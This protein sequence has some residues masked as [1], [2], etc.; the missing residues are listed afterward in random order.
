MGFGSVRAVAT[1]GAFGSVLTFAASALGSPDLILDGQTL[2]TQGKLRHH[3][4]LLKNNS[5]LVVTPYDGQSG[6][7]RLEIVAHRIV[8]EAGS[9]IDASGAGYPGVHNADGSGPGGG[10]GATAT[11]HATGGGGYYGTGGPGVANDCTAYSG[12]LGGA[13]YDTGESDVSIGSAGSAAGVLDADDGG[14]G[15]NGA[16]AILLR[17]GY[18]EIDGKV[19]ADG[20]PG[21]PYDHSDCAGGG[22]GGGILISAWKLAAFQGSISAAG[23]VG[24][25]SVVNEGGGGGGGRILLFVDAQPP[26]LTVSVAGGHGTCA[27]AFGADGSLALKP[28]PGCVDIDQ[29]GVKSNECETANGDCDDSDP[30]IH[31]GAIEICNGVDDDCSGVADDNGA[32]ASCPSGVCTNGSC[33]EVDAGADGSLPLPDAGVDGA[34]D[35]DATP[36]ADS[37][38]SADSADASPPGE[39][40][41]TMDLV[42]RGGCTEATGEA[43]SASGVALFVVALLMRVRRR[44]SRA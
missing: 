34:S 15:G 31:P 36:G 29:D 41:E 7:G 35:A 20:E 8:V 24:G 39:G 11:A 28:G 21:K 5:K 9:S 38:D 43:N 40:G 25:L 30:A 19:L 4:V 33:V 1:V 12:A 6:T 17:A 32:G 2:T 42:L 44:A 10:I 22:S 14:R 3:V 18:V 23:G 16:G 13:T 26:G 27:S 37:A